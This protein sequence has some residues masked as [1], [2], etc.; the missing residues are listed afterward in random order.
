MNLVIGK[1]LDDPW[2]LTTHN[3]YVFILIVVLKDSRFAHRCSDDQNNFVGRTP[4]RE[5]RMRYATKQ[6][7]GRETRWNEYGSRQGLNE[8]VS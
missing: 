2:H 6:H 1:T 4:P 3:T 7:I 8:R 5:H